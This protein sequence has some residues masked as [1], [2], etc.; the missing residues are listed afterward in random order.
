MAKIA[1]ALAIAREDYLDIKD[2]FAKVVKRSPSVMKGRA[3]VRGHSAERQRGDF[4]M[5]E[6]IQSLDEELHLQRKRYSSA[7]KISHVLFAIV[8]CAVWMQLSSWVLFAVIFI[9][10][11]PLQ[12]DLENT[13]FCADSARSDEKPIATTCKRSEHSAG[14]RLS[15][16]QCG[17][18][19]SGRANACRRNR[20]GTSIILPPVKSWPLRPL[21]LRAPSDSTAKPLQPPAPRANTFR[22]FPINSAN[23]EGHMIVL[24]KNAPCQARGQ[25]DAYFK[26]RTRLTANYVQGRFKRKVPMDQVLTGQT[27]QRPLINMP[28]QIVMKVAFGFLRGLAPTLHANVTSAMPYILTP[29]VAAARSIHAA[30]SS[31]DAPD[32]LRAVRRELSDEDM[33]DTSI[34]F[35]T[36]ETGKQ[37]RLSAASRRK[38]FKNAG[39]LQGKFFDPAHTYT[40]GFWQNRSTPWTMLPTCLLGVDVSSYLDGQACRCKHKLG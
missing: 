4:S 38:A 24:F 16:S 30:S 37:K 29:L 26:N 21:L 11:W 34:L 19:E 23:F 3:S 36:D 17:V 8:V 28:S 25:L 33:E 27:F 12:D 6:Q 7:R 39:A 32:L 2:V 18:G 10:Y 15:D 22:S 20:S 9:L 13:F 35:P 5:L 31:E 14:E 40:F 1:H